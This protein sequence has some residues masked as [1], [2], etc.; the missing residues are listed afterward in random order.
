MTG[1][2]KLL[3]FLAFIIMLFCAKQEKETVQRED[4]LAFEVDTAKL[5]LSTRLMDWGIELNS[6]KDWK[7]IDEKLFNQLSDKAAT[8]NLSDSTFSCQPNA[9]FFNQNDKSTLFI[10][11]VSGVDDTSS[12]AQYKNLIQEKLAPRKAGDFLKNQISFSQFLIQDELHVNFK[13]L[14]QNKRLQLIQFDYI[15]PI[16]SYVSELKAIE[17]SIG[18]IHLI[19]LE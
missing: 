2:Y 13:L 15:I 18:S 11:A 17:S 3:I 14:F 12:F 19:N 1:Y 16:H 8:V 10:S 9:I 4:E 6:P 7:P 5:E